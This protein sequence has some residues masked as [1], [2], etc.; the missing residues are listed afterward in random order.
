MRS[1]GRHPDVF[2]EEIRLGSISETDVAL[3]DKV[4]VLRNNPVLT[5]PQ[6]RVRMLTGLPDMR[7]GELTQVQVSKICRSTVADENLVCFEFAEPSKGRTECLDAV[8]DLLVS[9]DHKAKH[10]ETAIGLVEGRFIILGAANYPGHM[11]STVGDESL[12]V[13]I[14]KLEPVT[15]FANE[16]F[17]PPDGAVSRDWCAKS[18]IAKQPGQSSVSRVLFSGLL[19]QKP[20]GFRGYYLQVASNGRVVK[21][22]ELYSDGTWKEVDKNELGQENFP[23]HSCGGKPIDYETVFGS[24]SAH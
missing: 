3:D 18:E 15:R 19:S 4:Y 12:E 17:V 23:A 11:F 5:Y 14:E 20:K 22:A 21:M 2:R 1:C 10:G 6:F 8:T 24:F 7:E 13:N 9:V 16:V